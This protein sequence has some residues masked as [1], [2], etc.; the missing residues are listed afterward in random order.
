MYRNV[1]HATRYCARACSVFVYREELSQ[2]F[3]REVVSHEIMLPPH[4]SHHL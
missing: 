2:I 4:I 1:T 3:E